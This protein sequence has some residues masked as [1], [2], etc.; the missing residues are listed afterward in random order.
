MDEQDRAILQAIANL[1]AERQ[2]PPTFREV[3]TAVGFKAKSTFAVQRRLNRMRGTWVEWEPDSRRTLHLLDA[4]RKFLRDEID[5]FTLN[6]TAPSEVK[7]IV[8]EIATG[9][10]RLWDMGIPL[11]APK[12]LWPDSLY[13]GLNRLFWL[14]WQ[15]GE[16]V[17]GDIRQIRKFLEQPVS[18][19]PLAG[20]DSEDDDDFLLDQDGPT[21][22]AR[23]ISVQAG[24]ARSELVQEILLNVQRVCRQ[25]ANPDAYREFRQFLIENPV[26][27]FKV[28][29]NTA[30]KLASV[31][32]ELER[33]LLDAYEPLPDAAVWDGGIHRC[34]Y[35]GSAMLAHPRQRPRCGAST[36]EAALAVKRS[37]VTS[38]AYEP[39]SSNAR[40]WV[41]VK[42]G[43]QRS[44]VA[45][46]IAELRLADRLTRLGL[47][48]ELWP[49][50][51]QYDLLVTFPNGSIWAVDVKDF[52]YP[53]ALVAKL[54]LFHAYP[55]WHRAWY[56]V[57]DHRCRARRRYLH[58][59]RSAWVGQD[60]VSLVN[61]TEFMRTVRRSMTEDTFDA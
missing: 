39:V 6:S 33:L 7:R 38:T 42:S 37:Q 27:K 52:R 61:E 25:L 40:E 23:E 8:V 2:Q 57:P 20:L 30:W 17:P 9:L 59:A 5:S 26:A 54:E 50:F 16:A 4:G 11:V 10:V 15:Q 28:L 29:L 41:R 55:T 43:I 18:Q 58:T 24:D 13:H 12:S 48:V 35:C 60:N 45:P 21:E 46:G 36:C 1:T 22:Y 14:L 3:G 53:L 32:H 31:S 44:T 49:E 56:V 19:W 47:S 34:G 51:D